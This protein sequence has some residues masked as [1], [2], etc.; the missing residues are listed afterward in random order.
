MAINQYCPQCKTSYKITQRKCTHCKLP[1][2]QFRVRVKNLDDRLVSRVCST[3]GEAKDAV[4][5]LE[6]SR[7]KSQITLD[8]A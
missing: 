3:L 7:G 4:R 8:E 1:L 6:M 5:D 2:T